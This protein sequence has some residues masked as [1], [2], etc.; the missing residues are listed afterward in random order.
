MFPE[1]FV[2]RNVLAW[3]RPGDV[4][5]DPFC[6]RG[7]TVLESL[8]NSR[9]AIGCDTNPVAFTLSRAKADPPKLLEVQERL[10][11][12]ERAYPAFKSRAA[13]LRDEFFSLCFHKETLFQLLF[14]KKKL[15]W[16]GNRTDCFI[17]A[18]SLGCLHG[19]SHRTELCF[20][21]R[22]PRTISTKPAYSVRWWR[23]RGCIPPE[24]DVFSILRTCTE[25]RYGSPMPSLKGR[26]VEGD[27]RQAGTLLRSYRGKVKLAIT[28]PPY[29]DIT[30]YHE[31][32]WLR[33]WFLGGAAKPI[34]GQG[35]DDRHRRIEGYWQFLREAWKGIVPLL[36][37]SAQV[38]I[39][40][41]GTRLIEEDLRKGLLESLNST[42]R[43]FKLAEARQTVI[44]NGQ[45]RTFL[46][47]PEKIA[48]EHDYR[49]KLA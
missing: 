31:D 36:Q 39:R 22:M 7:T 18:L 44:R 2:R 14:L 6:G 3:S 43:K 30:D 19:E 47:A 25:Y 41:G 49:F 26:V 34:A 10:A 17:A 37:D 32:Q 45:R 38:V 13:E 33:L 8:L 27:V 12:L 24:R 11:V 28:S 23:E 4:I 42:G 5:L 29:L 20:S 21:N 46:T 16:R 9:R 1:A 48:V 40:I 15:N 35:R